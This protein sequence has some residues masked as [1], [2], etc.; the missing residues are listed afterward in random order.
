MGRMGGG[1]V[2]KGG[3]GDR[4]GGG[5]GGGGS[6]PVVSGPNLLRNTKLFYKQLGRR[7]AYKNRRLFSSFL[8]NLQY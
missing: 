8:C 5:G 1:W 4:G 7:H 6:T 2:K 3:G